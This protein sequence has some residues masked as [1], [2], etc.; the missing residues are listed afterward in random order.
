MTPEELDQTAADLQARE[1]WDEY[2][3]LTQD[4]VGRYPKRADVHL[5]RARALVFGADRRDDGLLEA[6]T[7]EEVVT[8]DFADLMR[9]VAVLNSLGQ[10]EKLGEYLDRAASAAS[11]SGQEGLTKE[12]GFAYVAG[13]V[14]VSQGDDRSARPLLEIAN[15]ADPLQARWA[16]DLA[17]LYVRDGYLAAA[18]SIAARALPGSPDDDRLRRLAEPGDAKAHHQAWGDAVV[19]AIDGHLD[20]VMCPVHGDGQLVWAEVDANADGHRKHR[21]YCPLCGAGVNVEEEPGTD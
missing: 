15:I 21:L 1:A 7:A 8:E 3:A 11:A 14:K 9:L 13:M 2:L 17:R 12:P 6:Q 4:L 16:I 19:A 5:H 18:S 20:G 10:V